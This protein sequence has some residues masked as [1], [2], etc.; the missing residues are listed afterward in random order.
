MKKT[1]REDADYII[2]QAIHAVQPDSAVKRALFDLKQVEGRTVV[3]S[4]G[5]AAWQ[6]AKAAKEVLSDR[7][8]AGVIICIFS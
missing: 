6:M 7:I 5:K 2:R 4:F 1:L 8:D 3:I